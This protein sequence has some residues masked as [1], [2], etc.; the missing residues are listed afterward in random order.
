MQDSVS[1]RNT[2]IQ[3]EV[4]NPVLCNTKVLHFESSPNIFSLACEQERVSIE[5]KITNDFSDF[6]D[7]SR[8]LSKG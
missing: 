7:Q 8:S 5:P 3:K 2:N 4:Y 6:G 1:S